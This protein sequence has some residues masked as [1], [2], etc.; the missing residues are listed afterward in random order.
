MKNQ[1]Y[2]LFV[3]ILGAALITSCSSSSD[4]SESS[5]I[6]KRKYT[7]GFHVDFG[8]KHKV[9]QSA[10]AAMNS[11]E[12][13]SAPAP[14]VATT[15]NRSASRNETE[16]IHT[17]E[18]PTPLTEE[19]Q[20]LPSAESSNSAL[21][22]ST[23]ADYG[24]VGNTEMD[25]RFLQKKSSSASSPFIPAPSANAASEGPMILYLILAIIIPPLAVGLLYG[26]GREFWIS[27]I[28]T[29]LL[30]VPGIIYAVIKVLA[31]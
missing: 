7:K 6:K 3:L 28:L 25:M 10:A 17:A 9:Q 8:K 24:S 14:E 16:R 27:L 4:L 2:H 13:T 5:F 29:L 15:S 30:L 1:F 21:T 31:H 19:M 26:I 11:N 12:T 20:D 23:N 22:A 18:V